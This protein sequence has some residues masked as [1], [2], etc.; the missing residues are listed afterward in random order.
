MSDKRCLLDAGVPEKQLD[1]I[2]AYMEKGSSMEAYTIL[3]TWRAEL[4][5][6]LHICQNQIDCL[7][8]FLHKYKSELDRSTGQ[9]GQAHPHKE[10]P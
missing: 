3:K 9:A 2:L 4:L 8:Y 6:R 1:M 5:A 7:D 10:K